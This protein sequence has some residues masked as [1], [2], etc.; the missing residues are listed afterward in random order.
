MKN[1]FLAAS[2]LALCLSACKN[3][4]KATMETET[5]MATD[6]TATAT[7][8]IETTETPMDSVAMQKAWEAY[9]TP[10]EP[11]KMMAED[12]GNWNNEMT[13]WMGE[14]G[15]SVKATSTA[16]INMIL[17]GRY[18]ETNYKGNVMDMPF[19]GKATTAFDNATK[20]TVSTWID[21]M[22]TGMMVLRGKYDDATKAIISNGN[23]VDPMTGK[24]R[25]VREV[26]TIVD[27][28]TRKME[29][30]ETVAGG[31]EY[32]SMEIVMKRI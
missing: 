16:E 4:N 12:V 3:E 10:S 22:G 13:F 1:L 23:M 6:T 2:V 29:M 7:D 19:E 28:N 25:Q 14:G 17:G 26:F 5:I 18:Q 15:E 8:S 32:K 24:E 20:E 30:F 11:H 31:S 9:A 21:N 27:E